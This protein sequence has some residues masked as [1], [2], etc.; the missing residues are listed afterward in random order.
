MFASRAPKCW[1]TSAEFSFKAPEIWSKSAEFSSV[2]LNLTKMM[3][4]EFFVGKTIFGFRFV[5][6]AFVVFC[7]G[8]FVF[9]FGAAHVSER[10]QLADHRAKRKIQ[11]SFPD[12][13]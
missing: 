1:S 4:Q 8:D 3:N 2:Y 9:P 10:G 13:T 6:N 12:K 7:D 5:F 11:E